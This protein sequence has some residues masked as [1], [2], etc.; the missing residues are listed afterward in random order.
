MV[1]APQNITI[2]VENNLP[3]VVCDKDANYAGV[4]ESAQ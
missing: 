3:E 2:T 1:A 4:R